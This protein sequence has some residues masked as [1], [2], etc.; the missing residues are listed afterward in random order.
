MKTSTTVSRD[1]LD[2]GRLDAAYFLDDA[3][4]IRASLANGGVHVLTAISSIGQTYA[5]SRFKRTYAVE[6][7]DFIP[8][9]RPYDV[10]EFLPPEADRLSKTRTAKLDDYLI[11]EG[12]IL[13]TCSGRNLGPVTI[14][15]SYLARF[16]LS[17]DMVRVR[18]DDLVD[19]YYVLAFLRSRTGQHLLRGDR[20][21][22][23]ISHITADH[24]GALKVPIVPAIKDTVADMA[25]RATRLR[26]FA[27]QELHTVVEG[28]NAAY[29]AQ[30]MSLRDGWTVGSVELRNR[31][32]SAFHSE[33]TAADKRAL[34]AAGGVRL[35][36]VA[37][38]LKPGGRH[39]MVYVDAGHG[40]PF[41]SGRQILQCDVVA[42]KYLAR[43]SAQAAGGFALSEHSIIFQSDGRAEEGLG[44]PAYVT[45]ERDGWLTS[46]HVG[47]AVPH[48]A[49]D[50]GWIW[51][52]M[53]SDV[54]RSQ[55]V[56]LSCGSVVDALYPGDLESVVLPPRDA[57]D[58]GR[59]RDAWRQMAEGSRLLVDASD[60]IDEAL[61]TKAD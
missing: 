42:A 53:A 15:D 33:P 51:A 14:A 57:A 41:L 26:E 11:R 4:A 25:Q 56:A 12:D 31:F 22:S 50:A 35:G 28:V 52:S 34:V 40:E 18:I 48:A 58:S 55:V 39:K 59:V 24:V 61:G 3:G 32:D 8:Y 10:F 6:G 21:G 7:E 38:I 5:P 23:V 49:D 9:L 29:P 1:L 13:Q 37:T 45:S 27:R 60:M 44:Y 47:R 20:G 19:R 46:G 43:Q 54:V 30:R 17:H 2:S 16:A 36:D